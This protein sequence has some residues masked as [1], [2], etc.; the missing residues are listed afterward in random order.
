[1]I[2]L[3]KDPGAQQVS[4]ADA[5]K[6]EQASKYLYELFADD[7]YHF[8]LFLFVL[9]EDEQDS[10]QAGVSTSLSYDMTRLMVSQVLA[11]EPT[12]EETLT[13]KEPKP[14]LN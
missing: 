4:D 9:G 11:D 10:V 7:K 6:L 12:S 14:T 5:A 3:S 2:D 8:S 1:M 13:C